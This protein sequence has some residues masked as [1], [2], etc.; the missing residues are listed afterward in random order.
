[1]MMIT[2]CFFFQGIVMM[3]KQC[4]KACCFYFEVNVLKVNYFYAK[5]Y[6]LVH[7]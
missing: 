7:I 4:M 1:M 3:I 5:L 2:S 6:H